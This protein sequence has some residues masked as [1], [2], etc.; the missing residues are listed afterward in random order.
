M[1]EV[2]GVRGFWKGSILCM[3]CGLMVSVVK[4]GRM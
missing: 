1:A 4:G 2:R 3:V